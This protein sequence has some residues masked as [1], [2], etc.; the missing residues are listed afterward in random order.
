MAWTVRS[1]STAVLCVVGVVLGIAAL[2]ASSAARAEGDTP[3][4]LVELSR[5]TVLADGRLLEMRALLDPAIADEDAAME[6]LAPGGLTREQAEVSAQYGLWRKWANE[7]VPV[8]VQYNPEWDP[9]GVPA[10]QGVMQWAI[11]QWNSIP[12][13]SFRFVE[14]ALTDAYAASGLCSLQIDDG[15]N[16]VRFSYLLPDGVLGTTCAVISGTTIDGVPRVYEFDLQLDAYTAWAWGDTTPVG[17]YDLPSTMLHELGHALGLDHSGTPGSTML[18]ALGTGQQ[19]RTITAD[20]TAGVL[21]LYGIAAPPT[22]TPTTFIPPTSTATATP[23][24]TPTPIVTAPAGPRPYVLR[25]PGLA[26]D[27]AATTPPP[28]TQPPTNPPTPTP[29]RTPV[30]STPTP[31]PR[32]STPTP[33]ATPP[34]VVTAEVYD[35][36]EPEVLFNDIRYARLT[37]SGGTLAVYVQSWASSGFTFY[38]NGLGDRSYLAMQFYFGSTAVG[39]DDLFVGIDPSGVVVYRTTGDD[40]TLLYSGTWLNTGDGMQFSLPS[41]LFPSGRIAWHAVGAEARFSPNCS[42]GTCYWLDYDFAPDVQ[43]ARA[44]IVIP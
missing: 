39:A 2:A 18:P 28:V 30:P 35:P 36:N 7:D 40:F 5:Y 21:A 4:G 24:R 8:V 33:T 31:T 37:V 14:G 43:L 3:S 10:G 32:P 27:D 29:T 12:G 22:S 41:W 9:Y 44:T 11:A 26:R 38:D 17:Y 23:T 25:A 13:S 42:S 16:S 15:I 34:V 20:D 19:M 6:E 1:L